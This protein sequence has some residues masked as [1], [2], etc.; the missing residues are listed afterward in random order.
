MEDF[1]GVGLVDLLAS[2]ALFDDDPA[3]VNR[4]EDELDRV[5]A[6]LV[7]KTAQ[8]WLRTTNRTVFVVK[9]KDQG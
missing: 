7:H 6:D 5:T 2:L 3:R 4:I 1:S 9:T 8:E